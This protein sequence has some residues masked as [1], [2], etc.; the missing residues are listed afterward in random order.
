MSENAVKNPLIHIIYRF[1]FKVDRTILY[2]K[3]LLMN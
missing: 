2:T 3:L 1:Y